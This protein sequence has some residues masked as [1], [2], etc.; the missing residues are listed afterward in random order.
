MSAAPSRN[1][2]RPR[3]S[4]IP[5]R[6][7]ATATRPPASLG[8]PAVIC[9]TALMPVWSWTPA[10]SSRSPPA[11]L[12]I[13]WGA[14]VTATAGWT[15]PTATPSTQC[16]RTTATWT[17]AI[18]TSTCSCRTS[19][20]SAGKARPSPW[21]ISTLPRAPT[22]MVSLTCP[23]ASTIATT[24][25]SGKT[26]APSSTNTPCRSTTSDPSTATTHS[27]WA[28]SMCCA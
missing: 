26:T 24:T 1:G 12:P 27:M 11:A 19:T 4:T 6:K 10:T 8:T 18:S 22:V 23:T 20:A 16:A 7:A 25:V 21:T 2:G 15:M 3:M 9:G 28:V 13:T 14:R 17:T 5:T